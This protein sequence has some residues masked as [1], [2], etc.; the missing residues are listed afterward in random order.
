LVPTQPGNPELEQHFGE[1]LAGEGRSEEGLKALQEAVRLDPGRPAALCALAWFL[2]T[3]SH[4][5]L[6]N[7]DEALQLAQDACEKTQWTDARCSAALDAAY[8]EVG[9][10]EDAITAAERTRTLAEAA[11]QTALA[12]EAEQRLEL[13]R[14]GRSYHQK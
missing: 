9:R 8:A 7:G 1:A 10:F 5:E 3:D 13:Y 6:R 4:A 11:G 2:A 12:E 14:K